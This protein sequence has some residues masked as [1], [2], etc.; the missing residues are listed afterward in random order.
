ML[1]GQLVRLRA[2]EPADLERVYTWINDREVTRYLT[3]RY[4]MSHVD[5]ERWIQKASTST[6]GLGVTLAIE[7]K[8]GDHIGNIDLHR[9]HPEDRK[10]GLGIM[11]GD[12]ER[13]SQGFGTDAMVTLLRFA[14][15]EMNLHRVWLTVHQDNDR[16][17][18]C[19]RKC[20]FVEEAR[21]RQDIYTQG[22][23][24]DLIFMGVLRDDFEALHGAARGG[25]DA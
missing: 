10:C 17:M 1:E 25:S 15:H 12:K 2:V 23:Y 9:S 5:E 8:A 22:R 6:F 24:L 16:A 13:W 21:Q 20:G 7:T 14:F 3:A 4:P 19:Y 11:L 18:A